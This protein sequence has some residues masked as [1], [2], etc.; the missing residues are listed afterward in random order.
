[1]AKKNPPEAP[2]GPFHNPFGALSNR[3]DELPAGPA[4]KPP[5]AGKPP[6]AR[7]VIRMERKGRGGKEVTVVEK[8]EQPPKELERWLKELK[9]A[10]GCGGVVEGD[11]LVLQGDQ[12]E[13]LEKVL[14]E[15]GIQRIS[16]G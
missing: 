13:R 3:R 15:K 5:P 6:P 11:S 12:R 14:R 2:K 9:Q 16:V 10:L 1:M 4:A 7:A 8:L